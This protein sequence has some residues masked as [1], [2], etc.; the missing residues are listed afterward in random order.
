MTDPVN[1]EW[2]CDPEDLQ[3]LET[4][5]SSILKTMEEGAELVSEHKAQIAEHEELLK[6]VGITGPGSVDRL[7]D[8]L[9]ELP[10]EPLP[11]LHKPK[12]EIPPIP[13]IPTEPLPPLHEQS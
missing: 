7:F 3:E 1:K 11:P 6:E 10:T 4:L 9:P 8:S 12:L 5:A 2:P 13:D